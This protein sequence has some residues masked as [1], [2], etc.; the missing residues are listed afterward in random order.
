MI[1]LLEHPDAEVNIEELANGYRSVTITPLKKDLFVSKDRWVT[2]YPVDL[3]RDMFDTLG[4][5]WLC[6]EIMREEDP[7]Y[8]RRNLESDLFAYFERKELEGR[9]IMDFGCGCGASTILLSRMFPGA[10]I[11][12]VELDPSLL[13]IARK[14]IEFY[15]LSNIQLRQSPGGSEL[16]RDLGQFE[17][18]IMSAVFE[19]FMPEE[20]KLL[21]PRI[22]ALVSNGGYLFLDQTPH[23]FFP[24]ELHTTML[25]LIN[26][27]PRPLA[28]GFARGFSR[29]VGRNEG[30]EALLRKGIRGGTVREILRLLSK[31]EGRPISLEPRRLGLRDRVDLWYFMTD[32][33]KMP[34]EKSLIRLL[35]KALKSVT[36]V[37]LV[38]CLS[39][40]LKKPSDH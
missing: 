26:Y 37:S 18:V 20:R 3:I 30:W 39:L 4:P 17:F 5:S 23:R 22:W 25:P 7:G 34:M 29:R 36:G 9:K 2:S 31:E 19:H 32:R 35:M 10:S 27:L 1:V 15:G 11:V 16:P 12:G 14:R 13:S 33:N 38:P 21:M 6:D 40:V 24:I 28:L 8:V